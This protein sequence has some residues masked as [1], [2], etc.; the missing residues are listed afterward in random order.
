M[1]F[2]FILLTE[3][4]EQRGFMFGTTFVCKS[5]GLKTTM[6]LK[7]IKQNSGPALF[8]KSVKF[9]GLPP[10]TSPDSGSPI[11]T[12]SL[13]SSRASQHS[14]RRITT[15]QQKSISLIWLNIPLGSYNGF[16]IYNP[17]VNHFLYFTKKFIASGLNS[18]SCF[19]IYKWSM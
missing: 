11:S 7:E 16:K 14:Y 2:P 1:L 4:K 10:S 15:R 13:V 18:K 19:C 9:V 5:E 6:P 17:C 3:I 8:S 12:H